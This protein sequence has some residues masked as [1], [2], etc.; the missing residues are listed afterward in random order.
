MEST[1]TFVVGALIAST[2]GLALVALGFGIAWW[3]TRARLRRLEDERPALPPEVDQRLE[4]LE[5]SLEHLHGTLA[6]IAA[7]QD[8]LRQALPPARPAEARPPVPEWKEPRAVTP[9]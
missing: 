2:K 1:L 9:R 8:Q 4:R 5:S 3:R 7:G 6:R